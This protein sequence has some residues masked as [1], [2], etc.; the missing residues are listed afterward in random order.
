MQVGCWGVNDGGGGHV[1]GGRGRRGGEGV[2]RQVRDWV[3]W[4]RE[5]RSSPTR[6]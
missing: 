2:G 3:G 6:W 1:G 5:E 4:G